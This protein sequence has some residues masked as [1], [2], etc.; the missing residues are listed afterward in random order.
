MLA[1]IAAAT[2]PM[3]ESTQTASTFQSLPAVQAGHHRR[4]PLLPANGVPPW[5]PADQGVTV[6]RLF[7]KFFFSILLAQVVAAV[8]IGG[9]IWL[10]NR[11]AAMPRQLDIDTGP[12]AED[13]IES[14]A[15]TLE[16]GGVNALQSLLENMNRHRVYAVNEQGREL[17]GRI[18]KPA[19]ILE[20]RR[21]LKQD[22]AQRVVREVKAADSHRYVL[23]LPSRENL[24]GM[25]MPADGAPLLRS[26][27]SIASVPLDGPH[28]PHMRNSSGWRGPGPGYGAPHLLQHRV[29]QFGRER[30]LAALP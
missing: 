22:G 11:D 5:L 26:L 9:A 8:G 1:V 13:A 17:L 2:L 7:W 14:A 25:G 6:G 16:F 27:A 10:K 19:M 12:R 20:A 21:L 18:V 29:R 23:F 4:R 24:G 28:P 3:R 30:H 15:A